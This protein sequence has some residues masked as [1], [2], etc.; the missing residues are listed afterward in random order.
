M[1]KEMETTKRRV[2]PVS[3][4][5]S[6]LHGSMGYYDRPRRNHKVVTTREQCEGQLLIKGHGRLP[7]EKNYFKEP[8]HIDLQL[9]KHKLQMKLK[10]MKL[11]K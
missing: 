8:I 4:T 10:K 1:D 9:E 11:I 5:Y 2:I 6:S 3:L 7:L